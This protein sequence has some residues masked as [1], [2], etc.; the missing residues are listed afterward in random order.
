MEGDNQTTHSMIERRMQVNAAADCGVSGE[1]NA[2][3]ETKFTFNWLDFTIR[4][5][6]LHPAKCNESALMDVIYRSLTL[7]FLVLYISL[8]I[9]MHLGYSCHRLRQW[10]DGKWN[11]KPLP[12][13]MHADDSHDIASALLKCQL[14]AWQNASNSTFSPDR[15]LCVCVLCIWMR[16]YVQWHMTHSHGRC[17]GWKR[18]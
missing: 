10:G 5:H 13:A 15:V 6:V 16:V 12:L 14:I 7:L 1:I 2:Q 3:A 18:N 9:A 8:Y 11:Q 4:K 17:R